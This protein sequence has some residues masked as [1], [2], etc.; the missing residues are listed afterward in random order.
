MKLIFVHG[1]AQED[2]GELELKGIWMDALNR[3][4]AKSG[5]V[6]PAGVEV[7]LPYYDGLL[8]GLI[9]LFK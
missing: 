7:D 3:G 2:F 5:L 9:D 8:K 1:R 6:L 4:L